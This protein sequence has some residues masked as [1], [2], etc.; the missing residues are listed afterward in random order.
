STVHELVAEGVRGTVYAHELFTVPP[1]VAP[2]LLE[3]LADSGRSAVEAVGLQAVGAFKVAMASDTE[4]IVLWAVPDWPTW[5]AYERAWE[6]GGQLASWRTGLLELGARYRRTL[7]MEAPL[8]PMRL[9]RQPRVE[10]RRPLSE[11]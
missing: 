8:S 2:Q 4:A 10:D 5:V 6:P 11:I 3:R 9:G 1:G 7:L